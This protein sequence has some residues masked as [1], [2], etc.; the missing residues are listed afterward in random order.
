MKTS[1]P[2]VRTFSR[3]KDLSIL[4]EICKPQ[5]K[6]ENE[7]EKIVKF[8][9]DE[10]KDFKE[11]DKNVQSK[12]L[13]ELLIPIEKTTVN[14][15]RPNENPQ[16]SDN[17]IK[18]RKLS[19]CE[20]PI[21]KKDNSKLEMKL[22]NK[23]T[24]PSDKT[25]DEENTTKDLVK[26]KVESKIDQ[27]KEMKEKSTAEERVVN[28]KGN[29]NITKTAEIKASIDPEI[30][31]NLPILSELIKVQETTTS[32]LKENNHKIDN[33]KGTE[34]IGE[35]SKEKVS[36]EIDKTVVENVE[37]DHKTTSSA[38]TEGPSIPKQA[39]E[40]ELAEEAEIKRVGSPK[41]L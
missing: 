20:D 31:A 23:S 4:K 14:N 37:K 33:E 34:N 41:I 10:S 17:Q 13:D 21:T 16:S 22:N 15:K 7:I 11:V 12:N 25:E 19:S 8:L 24:I 35:T 39:S 5:E 29:Q 1:Q 27:R 2:K 26:K 40:E 32:S 30:S 9:E 36:L 18:K 6:K 38:P 3:G 28:D